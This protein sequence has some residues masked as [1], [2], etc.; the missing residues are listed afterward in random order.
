MCLL[1]QGF[2]RYFF[3]GFRAG[4]FFPASAWRAFFTAPATPFCDSAS[5]VAAATRS[6]RGDVM[7]GDAHDDVRRA[8]LVTERAAHR[9]RA[10]PLPARAFVHVAVRYEQVVDVERRAGV[11]RL[12]LGVGN[13]AAQNFFHVARRALHGE[14]QNLQ[15]IFGALPANQVDD[16]A[17]LLRRH[18]HVPRHRDCFNCRGVQCLVGHGL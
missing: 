13:R 3:D 5:A 9:R 2:L 18:A 17:N 8:A 14:A 7:L 1:S 16:Q 10:Q 6:L 15:R 12:A 11:F 4:F